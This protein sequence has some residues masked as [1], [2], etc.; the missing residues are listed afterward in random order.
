MKKGEQVTLKIERLAPDGAG[1]AVVKDRTI[2]VKGA[3]PGDTVEVRIDRLKRST[4]R[5]TLLSLVEPG[6]ERVPAMC[7]HFEYCGGCRWQ[8]IPYDIQCGLKAGIVR[9][10]LSGHVDDGLLD[11]LSVQPSPDEFYYRNKME[12]SFD[13][14]PRAEK[15]FLGLHEYG[16]YDSVFDVTDCYLQSPV[17]NRI[18]AAA[19]AFTIEN[20]LSIYGLKSHRGLLRYLAVRDSKETGEV[21]VNL[22]TS[23]DPFPLAGEFCDYLLAEAPEITTIIQSINSSVAS[24]AVGEERKILHGPGSINERIGEYTFTISPDSFFQTNSRQAR[25]L[26][27]GIR[28]FCG[29]TGSER[30][31]DLYCGAGT[32]GIYLAENA[33]SVVGI[34]LVED[35]IMDARHNAELNGIS[36]I[37]FISG[38]VERTVHESMRDFDVLICDPPRAGIHP[39]AMRELVKMRVPRFVYVSCNIKA[40]PGDLETLKLAGYNIRDMRIFDMSPHT[41]HIETVLLLEL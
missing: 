33:D 27:D 24:I 6:V 21:M 17:S 1:V 23:D 30:V 12:F 18:L 39:R 32:I 40:L 22:V 3:I 37:S 10:Q 31:L 19:R 28:D 16:R 5:V 2:P 26:Y 14:P 4:A 11:G 41:P 29:L 20:G 38:Q 25:H 8:D 15:P 36:N 7:P 34:E 9:G 35:A 13:Q